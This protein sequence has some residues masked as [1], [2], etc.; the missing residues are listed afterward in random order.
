MDAGRTRP[1]AGTYELTRHRADPL[2][3]RHH[4]RRNHRA[5]PRYGV[6]AISG[7]RFA[8]AKVDGASGTT[9]VVGIDPAQLARTYKLKWKQCSDA[10]LATI[11]MLTPAG[12]QVTYT[13]RG[14]LDEG[15]D[16]GM[17][18]AIGS[19]R[20]QVKR[21]VRLQAV[22]TSLVGTLLALVLGVLFALAIS[23]PLEEQGFELT[24]P[25]T[26]LVLLVA[27]AAVAGVVASLWPARCGAAGRAAGARLR[28]GAAES[29]GER[30]E[31]CR[32]EAPVGEAQVR[33]VVQAD[34]ALGVLAED[35]RG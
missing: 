4:D 29:V 17:L 11:R 9:M 2:P 34:D 14:L 25:L 3:D 12:K 35:L 28:V 7:L 8:E 33:A 27:A 22:I 6:G 15:S 23:R 26:T 20:R 10:T 16:F 30:V 5:A 1:H 32:L 31:P 18:R 21:I 19:S 13:V 24:F